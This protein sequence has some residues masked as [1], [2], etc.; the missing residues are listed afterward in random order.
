MRSSSEAN[1]KAQ[2]YE[3]RECRVRENCP[4]TY[5]GESYAPKTTNNQT[6]R[7]AEEQERNKKKCSPEILPCWVC[8]VFQ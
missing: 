5:Q 7:K 1:G 2:I 8:T 3:E 4:K 6:K